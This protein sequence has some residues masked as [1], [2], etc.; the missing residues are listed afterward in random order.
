MAMN[1]TETAGEL[2]G[3]VVRALGAD[4]VSI[5]RQASP[6]VTLF[7]AEVLTLRLSDGSEFKLF[8]KH[9]G[10]EQPDQPDKQQRDREPRVYEHFLAGGH[11]LPVAR[12]LGSRWNE[13]A[14]RHE[15]YLEYIDDWS[16][17]YHDL[18]HWFIAASRLADM[19]AHFALRSR[20]L[21]QSDCLLKL[22]EQYFAAWAERA[23]AAVTQQSSDLGDR[24]GMIRGDYTPVREL[25]TRQP[26]TLVHNDL[27]CKNVIADR[28]SLPARI[29]IIDWEMAG[30]GCGL[31]D[32]VHLKY[33]LD[34][35]NDA[36]ML[37][38]Y[39]EQLAPTDLLPK[40]ERQFSGLLAA[41]ELHKTLYRLA[42]SPGWKLPT[43]KLAQWVAESETFLQRVLDS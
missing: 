1:E 16:L 24:I 35:A 3:E 29:C 31:L 32:L 5:A 26:H 6:F 10:L 28:S 15:L 20:D 33:G 27:A 13:G 43:E 40:D 18:E 23:Q 4:V 8:L 12:Y 2:P 19:H 17:R 30:V 7:P 36:K 39:R 14:S 11:D 21:C 38:I 41:C 34:P 25:L 22:D 37:A 9:L 42:H